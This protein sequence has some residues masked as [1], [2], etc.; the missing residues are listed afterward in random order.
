M[1]EVIIGVLIGLLLF[2]FFMLYKNEVTCRNQLIITGAIYKYRLYVLEQGSHIFLVGYSDMESYDR[3]LW[4][5]WDFGYKNILPR[6]LYEIVEP[7]IEKE[8]KNV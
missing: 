7:F 5:I 4:R 3:T 8:R 2:L 6:H 1:R